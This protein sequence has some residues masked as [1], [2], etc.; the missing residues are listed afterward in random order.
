MWAS[1]AVF[2]FTQNIYCY[3]MLCW[4]KTRCCF[5]FPHFSWYHHGLHP[6]HW[7]LSFGLRRG[8]GWLPR[9]LE[10]VGLTRREC[11]DGGAMFLTPKPTAVTALNTYLRI[12][13]ENAHQAISLAAVTVGHSWAHSIWWWRDLNLS[14]ISKLSA[15]KPS[16]K[17]TKSYWKWP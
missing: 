16:G 9:A 5:T 13:H 2:L 15:R 8:L 10:R 17:H 4:L 1:E 12:D 11:H 6:E 3:A 7:Y 14:A